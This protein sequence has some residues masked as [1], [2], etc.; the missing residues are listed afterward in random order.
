MPSVNYLV[1]VSEEQH[2]EFVKT[3]DDWWLRQPWTVKQEIVKLVDMA[4]REPEE[5]NANEN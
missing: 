5:K 2:A 1:V 3:M 4:R